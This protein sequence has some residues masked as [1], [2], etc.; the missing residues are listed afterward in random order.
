MFESGSKTCNHHELL[1]LYFFTNFT[2]A[3]GD[4]RKKKD[5]NMLVNL[6]LSFD[7]V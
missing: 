7:V 6:I 1:L 4:A 3:D 5:K 2:A